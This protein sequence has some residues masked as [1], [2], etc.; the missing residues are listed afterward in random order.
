MPIVALGMNPGVVH[1][2]TP[3]TVW[4]V[5]IHEEDNRIINDGAAVKVRLSYWCPQG[6]P[7]V[8]VDLTVHQSLP[9]HESEGEAESVP[10]TCKGEEASKWITVWADSVD[11]E[12]PYIRG[13][14]QVKASLDQG[15]NDMGQDDRPI[16]LGDGSGTVSWV[17]IQGA[18][19]KNGGNDV[20]VKVDYLCSTTVGS[21]DVRAYV[22]QDNGTE[23]ASGDAEGMATRSGVPC[24]G[25]RES[26]TITVTSGLP[27]GPTEGSAPCED[28]N[29]PAPIDGSD[30]FTVEQ[31][32]GTYTSGRSCIQVQLGATPNGGDVTSAQ[33]GVF[34][35][36]A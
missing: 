30:T 2:A 5:L 10:V 32:G 12:Q 31:D 16:R 18:S 35:L 15:G 25:H 6:A 4:K 21:V 26:T 20:K 29:N 24:T 17:S 1:A 7:Y 19:T 8:V 14:A 34:N 33:E 3:N 9:N 13:V 23:G 27:A 11:N 36:N 28:Q 22:D